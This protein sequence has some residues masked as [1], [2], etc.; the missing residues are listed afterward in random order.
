MVSIS[1]LL[2]IDFFSHF[3]RNVFSRR[4]PTKQ[5]YVS[6]GMEIFASMAAMGAA[7]DGISPSMV[8]SV[9][10]QQPLVV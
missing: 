9:Q 10:H 8:Q 7:G 6:S 4:C 5:G 1:V 2:S 3:Y